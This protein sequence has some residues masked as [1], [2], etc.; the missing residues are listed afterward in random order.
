M[1]MK[2][3]WRSISIPRD[4]INDDFFSVLITAYFFTLEE[5]K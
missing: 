2:N 1:I 4:K 3:R 5:S